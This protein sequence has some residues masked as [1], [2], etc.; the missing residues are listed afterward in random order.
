M[1]SPT[2]IAS[3][4]SNAVESG[5][6]TGGFTHVAQDSPLAIISAQETTFLFLESSLTLL[7]QFKHAKSKTC[8]VVA[9]CSF[10]TCITGKSVTGTLLRVIDSLV[11]DL[12]DSLPFFQSSE[13]NWLTVL[14]DLYKNVGR[15]RKSV[16]GAKVIKVFNHIIAH[17]FYHKIGIEVDEKLFRKLEEKK[18]RPKVWDV[19][20]FADAITG[21]LLF[22]AKAGRHALLTGSIEAFFVDETIVTTWLDAAS[23]LRKDAEFLSNPR[24]IGTTVPTYLAKIKDAITTGKRLSNIFKTGVQHTIIHSV[25]LELEMIEKR[26]TS[27]L[28]AASFRRAPIGIFLFGTA[29]VAKSFI[30]AGLFNHYCSVRGIEKDAAYMWTRD[31]ND[32]F[33]SGYKSHF[34]GVLYDDAAKFRS[35]KVTGV[36]PSIKDIISAI[37]NIPFI[38]NQ[39]ELADKGKVPFLSEWVGV[40]SNVGDL[41]ADQYYNSSAAFLRRLSVRITPIVK[42]QYRVPGEDRIDVT[43]F[44]KDEQYPDLWD[45]IVDVPKVNGM[46]G[47]YVPVHT[48]TSYAGLLVYMTGVYE[49]HIL[50][51]DRLMET[52]SKIGPEVICICKLPKSICQCESEEGLILNISPEVVEQVSTE[53]RAANALIAA[54]IAVATKTRCDLFMRYG[55]LLGAHAM[56]FRNLWGM[57]GIAELF[58]VEYDGE[59]NGPELSAYLTSTITEHMDN[60]S[61]CDSHTRLQLLTD[62]AFDEVDEFDEFISFVPSVGSPCFFLQEQL[63]ELREIILSFV[64]WTLK[65]SELALLDKYL[66]EKAPVYVANGWPMCDIIRGGADYIKFYSA[67]IEDP[68]LLQTRDYLLHKGETPISQNMGLWFAKQYFTRKWVYN[69]CNYLSGFRAVKYVV[70]KISARNRRHPLE[71]HMAKSARDYD[72][73]HLGSHPYVKLIVAVCGSITVLALIYK[74]LARTTGE[75]FDVS[76]PEAVRDFTREGE[77]VTDNVPQMDLDAVGNKPTVREAEKKNVWC[78][79]ERNIT[80]LDVDQRCP[81]NATQAYHAVRNNCLHAEVVGT[82]DGINMV[83]NTKVLVIDNETIVINNHAI[84]DA[85]TLTVW[86][87]PRTPEGVQPSVDINV[88]KDMLR[89][90]PERDLCVI[91]SW[92]LPCLFKAIHHLLPKKT[93]Q[94]VG[95]AHYLIKGS[96]GQLEELPCFGVL[97][98]PLNGLHGSPEVQMMAWSATPKRPTVAGECGSPLVVQTPIGTVI[99]GFHCGFS[100]LQGRSWAAP[101]Y[102]EDFIHRVTPTIGTLSPCGV[103]AQS[104]KLQ[105]TDKLYT[106]Y[107]RDGKMM[108]HGLLRGFRARPKFSGCKTPHADYVLS[109]ASEFTPVITD[110]LAR[111]N[112]GPWNG[113]QQ[114]LNNYLFPT[115]SMNETMLRA[116]VAAFCEHVDAGLTEDDWSDIHPVPLAVAVNGFPGIPNVDAQKFTTSGGHGHRGPKLQF[117]SEPEEFEEWT[118]YR[119][120]D[121]VI[122]SEVDAMREAAYLGVR[123]HCIYTACDKDEML[124]LKKVNA[125]KCRSI[126]MCPVAFLTNMR[127]STMGLCRVMIRRRDLFGIAVGLNTHSEEWDELAKLAEKIPGN[128]WIAGDFGAFE[129]VLSILLSN[130]ASKVFLYLAKRSGNFNAK[131]LLAFEVFLADTVNP[132]IDFYGTLITLLG[133]EA[134]GQQ[135]TTFFNCICN[136]LLHMYA[137]VDVHISGEITYEKCL[138]IAREFFKHVFRNTLGDDVYLKV[139]PARP[140]YNH[141]SIKQCFGK[142]GIVYTMAD[143]ES[144]SVPYIDM[145]EVTFLKRSFRTHESFPGMFVATLDKESIYKMLLYTIPSNSVSLEEQLASA[146]ASA[147]AES[148]FHGREFYDQV[149]Q[150]IHDIPK[151]EELGFRLSRNPPPTWHTMVERFVNASPKLQAR[152]LVPG[153]I[154]ETNTTK[155]SY[156]HPEDF[157]FQMDWRVD[158]WGSTTMGRSPEERIYAGVRLSPKNTH[159]PS[160]AE[161][162]ASVENQ[163]LTKNYKKN[164]ETPRL[165]KE[166]ALIVLEQAIRKYK[167]KQYKRE[168]EAKWTKFEFQADISYD[169]ASMPTPE[170]ADTTD[171]VQETIVFKNEPKSE[172]YD[173]GSTRTR[174]G[175]EM[176]M[177]QDLAT[178][179]RRPR[180]IYSYAWAE[181]GADGLKASFNPWSL[182]Y[183]DPNMAAKL[184]GFSMLRSNLHL[185]FLVNGSPFYYGSL[186]ACW[187][188]L[189]G[190]RADTG[191]SATAGMA[192]VTASQKPHV[193]IENQNMSSVQMVLPFLFPYPYIDISI[194]QNLIDMGNIDL[195]QY[196]PLLSANGTGA[197]FIDVQV[198]AWAEDVDLSGPTDLPVLQSDFKINGQVSATASAVAGAAKSLEKAPIIGPYAMATKTVA[199]GVGQIASYFG[200]TNVPVIEDVKPIKQM[201][202]Q[203]ASAHISEPAN[204]LSLQ[205]KQEIALGASQHG[206]DVEDELAISHF[207]GR[208]SFVVGSDWT[209]TA[210]PGEALFTTAVNPAMFQ[211]TASSIAHTP[212]SY[213]AQHF[214]YWRGSLRY[215]FKLVRSPYHRGRI[216]ISWDRSATNLNVGPT[217][218]NPNTYTTIMDLDEDSEASMVVPYMQ[219]QQFLKTFAID[220]TGTV[221]WNTTSAPA[222]PYPARCNGVLS[223]RVVNRLTAPEASSSA[224]LLVFVSAEPDF[225]FA[226][227]REFNNVNGTN[228]LGLSY[229]TTAVAQSDIKRSD[230]SEAHEFAKEAAVNDLYKEVFG[231]RIVSMRE[232][233][234]RSSLAY[235][236]LPTLTGAEVGTA[237]IRIPV[238]RLPPAPG[239]YNNGWWTGT[240]ASGAG[241]FVNYTRFHPLISLTSCFVGY[242]G[243]TNVTVNV[244]QPRDTSFVD[245]LQISRFQNADTLSASARRP[246]TAVIGDMASAINVR[247]RDTLAAITTGRA[248]QALTNTKTNTGMVANLPYYAASGFQLVNFFNEYSNNDTLTDSN[249]DWFGIEWR[250]N[251]T[252]S[253]T[254]STGTITNVYYSS[255]PDFDP[256]FFINVPILY[257]VSITPV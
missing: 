56:Y 210:P 233:L 99:V 198:Y 171:V 14:E 24:A 138:V 31:D 196:A 34:A 239:V 192:L 119:S 70:A 18:I 95:N 136:Q 120:Y 204:K 235:V 155:S 87:G 193:W 48:F 93:F 234:H 89:R 80:R 130:G 179:L 53:R 79:A 62:N 137:Y 149:K 65:D 49:K 11:H 64:T 16:L 161:T 21:L 7:Y 94:S 185:K 58:D 42:E 159:K 206:G 74:L 116:C 214:Q 221:I 76:S 81:K 68:V 147:L 13:S 252:S 151:N 109:R 169:T 102:Q 100:M 82:K 57:H 88:T 10:F 135:L 243:S 97:R 128:N 12:E 164:L 72:D 91:S 148:F 172:M 167:K 83:A 32:D 59:L 231:E 2:E 187:N 132:S 22:L 129:S 92:S 140:A 225:E 39:A 200:Y 27:S 103:L 45:F 133:G 197:Q 219:P 46:K 191:A 66:Y 47:E 117:L 78:V 195:Y 202:F 178:Y 141:T 150:L 114:I 177:S 19:L 253:T 181:N 173:F 189:S 131:E 54:R 162:C 25:L 224:R 126:Y 23:R 134:S 111:P 98:E 229:L 55:H 124:S 84:L 104:K 205:P 73:L 232:Y 85:C 176:S 106:D 9:S 220:N 50:A 175:S 51:Q 237:Q 217:V 67:A 105:P 165:P 143:K 144:V 203:L 168:K 201:P 26:H 157:E 5:L 174:L 188:P 183:N 86:F 184:R 194:V 6:M 77:L 36:D 38:T 115:H 20:S 142:M 15:A 17:T 28:I 40:T 156:C 3:V 207:A 190:W 255:G 41:N 170:S 180:L 223:V 256:V 121:D 215:T 257:Q 71:E 241:Q 248:G 110:R 125:G 112:P 230:A 33:Y 222:G 213:L 158:S 44:P 244:D 122:H 238:K 52:T 107:H 199:N 227:P 250:Y 226:A 123:P 96:D 209:T 208:T 69:T 127:M 228:W 160:R 139:S 75:T 4:V 166:M 30:A 1:F 182:F 118:H 108:V 247:T 29:G 61:A 212:V 186:L 254:T 90:L 249:N 43:K 152:Q 101:L 63:S 153:V 8:L 251:K 242:K 35:S 154:T 37:N 211:K 146:F 216:Q 218:G 246:S 163:H 240:T 113:H 245:T 236:H 60:F 145:S